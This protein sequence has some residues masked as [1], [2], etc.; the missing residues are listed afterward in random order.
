M[1]E[2][3]ATRFRLGEQHLSLLDSLAVSNGG[4]RAPALRDAIAYWHR[5]ISEAGAQ[6]VAE[7]APDDWVR[8]AHLNDPDPIPAGVD[9]EEPL[10]VDWSA[11]LAH[12]LVGMW[13]GRSI[14]LPLHR[15]EATACRELARRIAPWG[16]VRGYALFAALR[17]FWRAP[18][19]AAQWW[20]PEVWMTPVARA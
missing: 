12:E 18:E 14:T 10:A 16:S 1:A 13:E 6:N 15:E 17:H 3:E 4:V 5:L 20:Q 19:G 9:N 7:L 11:R 2:T 8:L